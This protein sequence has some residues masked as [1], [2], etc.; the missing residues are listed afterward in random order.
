MIENILGGG[1]QVPEADWTD[2][3][4]AHG[5]EGKDRDYFIGYSDGVLSIKNH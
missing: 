3:S 2:C 1:F 5:C 4:C